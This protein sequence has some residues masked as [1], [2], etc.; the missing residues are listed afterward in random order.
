MFSPT[1]TFGVFVEGYNFLFL[2]AQLAAWGDSSVPKYLLTRMLGPSFCCSVG[3]CVLCCLNLGSKHL[4]KISTVLC[5]LSHLSVNL[6]WGISHLKAIN[7]DHLAGKPQL[8]LAA[9]L[10]GVYTY[11][12]YSHLLHGYFCGSLLKDFWILVLF[13]S[14]LCDQSLDTA[15]LCEWLVLGNF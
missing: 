5:A 4:C 12:L 13:T 2:W 3:S 11:C 8:F 9:W 10:R 6:C 14:A 15:F 1:L 7:I